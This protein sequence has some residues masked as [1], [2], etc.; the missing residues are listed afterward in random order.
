[1]KFNLGEHDLEDMRIE[2]ISQTI[3]NA[4]EEHEVDF[5]SDLSKFD[6]SQFLDNGGYDIYADAMNRL[7]SFNELDYCVYEVFKPIGKSS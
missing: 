3:D 5:H 6:T 4:I 1:M 7:N 2:N